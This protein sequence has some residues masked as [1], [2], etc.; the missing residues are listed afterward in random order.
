MWNKTKHFLLRESERG[1]WDGQ[2][3]L[4]Q[5]KPANRREMMRY[6][7]KQSCKFVFYDGDGRRKVIFN[8]FSRRLVTVVNI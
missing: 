3:D 2:I 4:S 8:P 1:A 7:R 6:R 5:S